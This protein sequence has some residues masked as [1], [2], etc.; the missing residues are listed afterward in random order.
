MDVI[1]KFDDP[2]RQRRR[3][4]RLRTIST[5]PTLLTLGNLLC[6][7]AAIHYCLR[8]MFNVGAGIPD[9]LS[10]TLSSGLMERALPSYLCISAF[11][12]FGGLFFDMLD[13]RVARLTRNT[14][15]FGGQ[16]DSL[17]DVVSFGVA[18][19]ML[20]IAV[21]TKYL[22]QDIPI[23]P[24]SDNFI[25]RGV[26][27]TAAI[28]ASCAALRLARFNV[29]HAGD[30]SAHGN[31]YGL[32]S[33]G[34]AAVVASLVLLHE[35]SSGV[36]AHLLVQVLPLVTL[37]V[38]LLMVSRVRYV[39]LANTYLRGRRPFWQVVLLVIVVLIFLWRPA[40][41]LALMACG[42]ATSG[43][44]ATL[45]RFTRRNTRTTSAQRPPEAA[46]EQDSSR[47]QA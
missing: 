2:R 7:F 6:G 45:I 11:L 1:A 24:L 10:R 31:F 33:P 46:P 12:V 23:A 38:G 18:P 39:H 5:C 34:A 42:Y 26:W 28:Y 27:M 8:A 21:T 41:I 14:S 15:T 17:A 36:R 25:G 9:D 44:L 13:G 35:H 32:A 29:E 37:A 4:R 47:K 30:D 22:H 19:A 40:P 43:P 20:V 16:L 3:R